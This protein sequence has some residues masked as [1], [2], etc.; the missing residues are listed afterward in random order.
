MLDINMNQA[1]K[2]I[3]LELLNQSNG[4]NV[5]FSRI[6]FGEVT[7]TAIGNP[8]NSQIVVS[9]IP[10]TVPPLRGSGVYFY[11]RLDIGEVLEIVDRTVYINDPQTS[12]DLVGVFNSTFGLSIGQDDVVYE[13]VDGS[14]YIIKMVPGCYAFT[15]SATLTIEPVAIPLIDLAVDITV[16]ELNGFNIPSDGFGYVPDQ[17][18]LSTTSFLAMLNAYNGKAYTLAQIEFSD[19]TQDDSNLP[20]NTY[21]TVSAKPGSAYIGSKRIFYRRVDISDLITDIPIVLD[22]DFVADTLHEILPLLNATLHTALRLNEVVDV[23]ID[24]EADTQ[25]LVETTNSSEVYYPNSWLTI[26]IL[27]SEDPEPPT[28]PPGTYMGSEDGAFAGWDENTIIVLETDIP[29]NALRDGEG[30]LIL[31]GEGH[32]IIDEE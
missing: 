20:F 30:K 9:A 23:T 15:G 2:N 13:V 11:N 7:T 3:I 17:S 19:I 10:D 26:N 22:N 14:Q 8:F 4:T 6:E 29:L 16:D 18:T 12:Y 28:I 5:T 24:W 21:L 1:P 27:R 25:F 31:D 32:I